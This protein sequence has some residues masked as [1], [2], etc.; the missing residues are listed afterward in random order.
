MFWSFD[1]IASVYIRRPFAL[2]ICDTNHA[3]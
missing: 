2:I 1:L 3:H